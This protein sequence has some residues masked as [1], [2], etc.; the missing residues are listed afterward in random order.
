MDF[1]VAVW[2]GFIA[3]FG[4][5]TETGISMLV[6]LREAIDKRGG[7]ENIQSLEELRQAVIEGAV[8]RLR[9]K[10]LTEGVAII[11]I[12]PMVFAKG[13][14]GEILAPMA[15]P[16][17]G[18]LQI[19]DEVVDLFLPRPLLLG[20]PRQMAEAAWSC[21]YRTCDSLRVPI[22]VGLI[23]VERHFPHDTC[24]KTSWSTTS[25]PADHQ[26]TKNPSNT[27]PIIH[28]FCSPNRATQPRRY[29]LVGQRH[30]R[31]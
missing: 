18:G 28:H 9:P 27:S 8:H 10:L 15:V 19:S 7:L 6:Y 3:C 1:S 5:A 29:R 14:G 26:E 11:A 24:S 30:F 13:V 20:P 23:D 12:F 22:D 16:V 25:T 31:C 17:L 2:V 21:R 4:M